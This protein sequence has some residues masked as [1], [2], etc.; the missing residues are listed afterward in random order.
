[1]KKNLLGQ[2]QTL[3]ENQHEYF[4]EYTR[5]TEEFEYDNS[6]FHREKVLELWTW[7]SSDN[8]QKIP[9]SVSVE[10]L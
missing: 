1:M 3:N 5:E 8:L 9:Y 4:F 10:L 2:T 7:I 6:W